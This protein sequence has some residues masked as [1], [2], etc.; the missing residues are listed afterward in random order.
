MQAP[1]LKETC[2]K[3]GREAAARGRH[4]DLAMSIGAND[5]HREWIRQGYDQYMVK[6]SDRRAA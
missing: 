3:L 5:Q 4:I 1:N 6:Y 2:R